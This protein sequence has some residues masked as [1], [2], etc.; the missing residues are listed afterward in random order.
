[1]VIAAIII[2]AMA[3]YIFLNFSAINL[4]NSIVLIAVGVIVLLI[5][6][7]ILFAALKGINPKK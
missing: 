3:I 6:M 5:V 7:G 2:I 1:M 4:T